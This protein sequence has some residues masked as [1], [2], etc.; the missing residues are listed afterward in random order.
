MR[1]LLLTGLAVLGLTLT[2]CQKDDVNNELNSANEQITALEG[3][4]D[5]AND[6]IASLQGTILELT[7]V[8]NLLTA[9]LDAI[10]II[11]GDVNQQLSEALAQGEVDAATIADLEAQVA[12]LEA[13]IIETTAALQAQIDELIAAAQADD[14]QINNL[15]SQL[16]AA[17]ETIAS[18]SGTIAS[19]EG[20]LAAAKAELEA[21]LAQGNVDS[22]TIAE[23]QAKVSDLQAELDA[24]TETIASLNAEIAELQAQLATANGKIA[25]LIKSIREGYLFLYTKD[26]TVNT[27]EQ[28]ESRNYVIVDGDGNDFDGADI[29]DISDEDLLTSFKAFAAK[30]G[31]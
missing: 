21:A 10:I 27:A 28:I 23:L 24:A 17:N 15:L 5:V 3:K 1:K 7:V 8:N 18:Q 19:L 16:D 30:F 20:E 22:A 6:Q 4:L 12:N 11:A 31:S 13:D 26:A 2:S 14:V 25:E 29:R 9:D